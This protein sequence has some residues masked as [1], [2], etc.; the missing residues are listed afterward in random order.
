MKKSGF[1]IPE[2]DSLRFF[3]FLLV[4]IYHEGY[5]ELVNS[6]EVVAKYGWMGVDL[7]LCFVPP[8]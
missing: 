3:V 7:F 5:S 2:L 4:L 8:Y 6:W 1:Y